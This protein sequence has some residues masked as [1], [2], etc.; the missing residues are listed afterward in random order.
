MYLNTRSIKKGVPD[1]KKRFDLFKQRYGLRLRAV[2]WVTVCYDLPYAYHL[3]RTAENLTVDERS[4]SRR[5][6]VKRR[7]LCSIA[8]FK[9]L[10]TVHLHDPKRLIDI[11]RKP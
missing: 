4:H 10:T 2:S 7:R 8:L 1:F 6:K 9:S 11:R 5:C 3:I